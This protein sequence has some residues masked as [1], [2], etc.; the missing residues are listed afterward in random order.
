MS[1]NSL[2]SINILTVEAAKLGVSLTDTQAQQLS[3]YVHM[4]IEYDKH[5]NLVGNPD[6]NCLLYEHILDSLSLL[7]VMNHLEASQGKGGRYRSYNLID[8][9]PGAGFPGLVLAIARTDVRLLA[10]EA[11]GKK[12]VFLKSVI[13]ALNLSQRVEIIQERAEQLAHNDNHRAS[14]N[15]VT[16]RALGALPVVCEITLPFLKPGGYAL[17]QRGAKQ[18]ETEQNIAKSIAFK[19]GAKLSETVRL[20]SQILGKDHYL[21]ILKQEKPTLAKF[22]RSWS[23]IKTKPLG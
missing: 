5:T 4:L 14:F 21:L 2:F 19:L 10:V 9:G 15:Y 18:F 17:L 22:P 20:D 16:C 13:E 7:P 3:D 23:D 12:V 8:I 6:P 11:T 1:G